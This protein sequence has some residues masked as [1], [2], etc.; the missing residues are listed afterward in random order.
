MNNL[1]QHK[2]SH[3]FSSDALLLAEFTPLDKVQQFADLGTGCGIIALELLKKNQDLQAI[4]IDFDSEL[5][6]TASQN[7]HLYL[8]ENRINLINED[9][10]EIKTTKNAKVIA[11]KNSCELVVT[12]PPWYLESQGK[13]PKEEMK[14]KAL[15]GNKQSY[16]HFFQAAR[17]FL[18][19]R[20][21][22]SFITIPQRIEDAFLAL[23]KE[24]FVLK[25]MQYV[26]KKNDISSNAIFVMML[27]QFKGKDASKHVSDLQILPPLFLEK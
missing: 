3:K 26:H 12:N 14:R 10:R 11:A 13:L 16:V 5:L 7:A 27:A 21:F 4:A 25:K 8:C 6:E 23:N 19:E 9:I 20:G 22:L 24:N 18:K 17:Y 1:F 2:D 15:F